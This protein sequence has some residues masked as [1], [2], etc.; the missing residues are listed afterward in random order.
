[1][2]ITIKQCRLLICEFKLGITATND[3]QIISC[4]FLLIQNFHSGDES[5][6]NETKETP[7]SVI[8]NDQLN[9][10]VVLNSKTTVR[11]LS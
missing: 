2:H 3:Q 1:M 10:M 6:E 5:L 11:K 4:I 7:R 8:K 9:A